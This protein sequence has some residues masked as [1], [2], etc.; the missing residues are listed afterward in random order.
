MA[1]VERRGRG[2]RA[3]DCVRFA[4]NRIATARE[5]LGKPRLP[6]YED[7]VVSA[8]TGKL[9]KGKR[10]PDET[11]DDDQ[12]AGDDNNAAEGGR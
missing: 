5:R 7:W 4:N 6:W 11:I 9:V 12:D 1:R 8:K 10:K 2:H 3:D